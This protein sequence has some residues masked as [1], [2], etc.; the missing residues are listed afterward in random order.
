MPNELSDTSLTSSNSVDQLIDRYGDV[1][2]LAAIVTAVP[3]LG[4]PADR[5][6]SGLAGQRWQKRIER[7]LDATRER[8]ME[9]DQTTVDHDFL[10]SEEFE[11]IVARITLAAQVTHE[12]DELR[13]FAEILTDIVRHPNVEADQ[14]E[15]YLSLIQDLTGT[16][17]ALIRLLAR[18]RD[19]FRSN[20]PN[21]HWR[22]ADTASV[23]TVAEMADALQLD[24][25]ETAGCA[26]DLVA[27]GLAYDPMVGTLNYG[28]GKFT[29][30]ASGVSLA[31]FLLR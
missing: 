17:M 12:E 13:L 24:Q 25:A 8:L 7:I 1:P 4:G 5:L 18:R 19:E 9:L 29:L 27:R 31:R 2:V 21:A 22:E 6:L 20:K 14:R 15:R 16:H 30:H 26:A 28:P 11:C 10:R 23:M 3:Y